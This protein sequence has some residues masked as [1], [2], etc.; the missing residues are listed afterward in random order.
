MIELPET[1]PLEVMSPD[2]AQRAQA[3]LVGAISRHFPDGE[4]FR[5][6][7]GVSPVH[8]R[9][10]TTVRA[11][12]AMAGAFDAEA[13]CLVQGAGTG[14]IRAA[15]SAGPWAQG[16][17]RLLLHD[18]P[19]YSTTATTFSDGQVEPIRVDFNDGEAL[20]TALETSGVG[21]LYL[22]HSRQQLTDRYRPGEVI[23]AARAAGV[24]VIVDDNY[25]VYRTPA[26]GTQLGASA[27]AFS[28]FKLHGPEG[29]GVVVGD[30]DVVD[31]VHAANYSGGGQVQGPQA[32]MALQQLV[33]VPPNWALQ[34]QQ[35]LGL[36]ERLNAGEVP[37]IAQ[38]R[39][40]NV[41]DLCA[42]ALLKQPVAAEF[43]R[44]AASRGGAPYPVGSNS[45]FEILPMVYRPSGANLRAHPNLRDRAL[46]INPM[47]GSA[48]LCV[49]ILTRAAE[50]IGVS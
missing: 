20:R 27:S 3:A 14:A 22:Q 39:A 42:I 25:T 2:Q 30:R 11:E 50:D 35:V 24:R 31:R 6:D 46:R 8:G 47:R 45:R 29:V 41:Q 10:D 16:Q 12:R 38:A 7:V 34:S 13:A 37:G 28:L 4:I 9:P 48:D 26:M 19:D 15:L 36:V 43:M 18:A 33:M 17:R 40:A 49:E 5:S 32:L 44:A 1:S 23:A 21:W